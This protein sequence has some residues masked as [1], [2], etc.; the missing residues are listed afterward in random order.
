VCDSSRGNVQFCYRQS[1][2]CRTQGDNS[3][4]F[5]GGRS[6]AGTSVRVVTS[7]QQSGL[8]IPG[9]TGIPCAQLFIPVQPV[10]IGMNAQV[11]EGRTVKAGYSGHYRDQYTVNWGVG[12]GLCV[13]VNTILRKTEWFR[14]FVL[15]PPLVVRQT[16]W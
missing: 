5:A 10:Q 3:N 7:S 16:C 15:V 4:L 14:Y 1:I 11:C 13:T 12:L 9:P 2:C 6:A 8:Q